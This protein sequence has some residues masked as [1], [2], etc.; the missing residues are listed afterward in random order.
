MYL[1]QDENTGNQSNSMLNTLILN[2]PEPNYSLA[3]KNEY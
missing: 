1:G 3:T 2:A